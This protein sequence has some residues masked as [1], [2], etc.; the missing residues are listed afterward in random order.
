MPKVRSAL[1]MACLFG[2][3]HASERS[4]GD[5]SGFLPVVRPELAVSLKAVVDLEEGWANP[6]T[7][8][9]TRCWWWWL[10]G[11]VT[12]DGITRDLEEMKRQ[13]LG[14]AS[15]VDA[16]GA[17]Q[18][19]NRQ[20]PHGPDF[21]SPAWQELFV[22]ALCEANRLGLELG[23]NIQSGWNLGGPTV[24]PEQAAKKLTWSETKIRGG[25]PDP[26]VLPKPPT[27]GD[28]YRDVA[29]LAL[30][31]GKVRDDEPVDKTA[32]PQASS[33]LARIENFR[34]K[35]YHDYPGKFTAAN[36]EHLLKVGDVDPSERTLAADEVI[37]LTDRLRTD[38][39]IEGKVPDGVW[40]ILRI[41][42]TLSGS[43]VSTCSEGSEGLAIDHLDP[44][45]F[46][47]YWSDVVDPLLDAAGTNVGKSLRYLHTDSLELGPVN[48]TPRMATEFKQ[49]RGY[50][51][52][53]YLPA[54]FGYVID[55]RSTSNRFLNDF[56]RTLADAI[57]DGNYGPFREVSHQRG[58]A[59]HPESGGPH[60]V[61]VDA[62][63]CLGRNDLPMGEF[64]ARSETHR[65]QD[66]QR[67]FVKQAASAAHVYGR[68]L[69]L[70]ESF[71]SIGPQWEKDPA[72]LKPVF[73]RVACEGLNL[74]ML[75][76]FAA[77]TAEMGLPGQAY[78]AGSHINPNTTWWDQ[79][80][81]FFDYLNRCQ[82]LLQQGV[83]CADV[84]HF[85][86]EN[87]PSFVRLKR[88]NPAG[89][90]TGHGY[91]VVNAEALIKRL[92]VS[93][94]KLVFPEGTQYE[95]LSLPSGESYSLAALK[96]I[97]ELADQGAV[98]VGTRPANPIGLVSQADEQEFDRLVAKLW[99][100]E[101]ALRQ[102]TPRHALEEAGLPQDF[103]YK[104]VKGPSAEPTLDYFHRRT[105]S[106]EIYFVVN[107]TDSAVEVD[108]SF[109]V[110]G[111]APQIWDPVTGN[112]LDAK[113]F[114]IDGDM[115]RLPLSMPPEAALFVIFRGG[116]PSAS[117]RQDGP[118]LPRVEPHSTLALTWDVQFD[119][120]L[121]GPEA[122]VTMPALT[123]WSESDEPAIRHYSGTAVYSAQWDLPDAV[124]LSQQQKRCWLDLGEVHNLAS[125]TLNG[126][127]CGIAWTP[128]YRVEVTG[129]LQASNRLEVAVVNLWP[130]RLIG[131]AG[132]PEEERITKT[133]ITK[134]QSDTPLLR[135]G[136]L[137]PV[138]LMV[139]TAE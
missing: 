40:T 93:Q 13:G 38:G 116:T 88:D 34:Q 2:L 39:T 83:S 89:D 119:R 58:I 79:S 15:I 104:V 105:D 27:K 33:G 114:R 125:V 35:A 131:D 29:V 134:F 10:N 121:G 1:L 69:V 118:N 12:K 123:D 126:E 115:T 65:V 107:R 78:F 6:P 48:W 11:N 16:G 55:D 31:W 95:L 120:Q 108:C 66:V 30:P 56:R 57:I 36:A 102:V 130:N 62:L 135:S 53:P 106:A 129:K 42:Y 23:L 52:K 103:G 113:T 97:A 3:S 68:R 127:P 63:A 96:K 25:G 82:F 61:A 74:V 32:S 50:E 46:A 9:K 137:G 139:E 117:T 54:L 80:K 51:L 60:A 64:W 26:I 28:Y 7:L 73:D 18:Q 41:G 8:A 20:V 87:V 71:T 99:G 98:I 81:A 47:K 90:L 92:S 72:M 37:D 86:G 75:H 101:G 22:H 100:A 44:K 85:Y 49:R 94:G 70:A 17:N 91:D 136:L 110:A 59:I 84:L 112:T 111:A 19:G 24:T 4:L 43:H 76:T 67:L 138:S 77:T 124:S 133:N 5:E 109:R 122:A 21:G 128:P 14:G 45:A 132:L